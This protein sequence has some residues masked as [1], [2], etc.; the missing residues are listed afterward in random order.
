MEQTGRELELR[1]VAYLRR[2]S[3]ALG[4]PPAHTVYCKPI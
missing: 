2:N 4:H 3:K 1:E